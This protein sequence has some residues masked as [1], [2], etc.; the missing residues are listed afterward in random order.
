MFLSYQAWNVMTAVTE[1]TTLEQPG[2]LP[3]DTTAAAVT[4]TLATSLCKKGDFVIIKD[5]A[6]TADTN[7][8]TVATEGAETIDGGNTVTMSTEYGSVGFYSNGSNWFRAWLS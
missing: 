6:G 1:A 2:I 3:V 8:I 5:A 4:V 7:N